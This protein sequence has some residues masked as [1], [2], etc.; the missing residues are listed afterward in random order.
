MSDATKEHRFKLITMSP[1]TLLGL[2]NWKHEKVLRLP[3]F[4][5]LPADL[6]FCAFNYDHCRDLVCIRVASMEFEPVTP[7]MMLECLGTNQFS[8]AQMTR[9]FV[10]KPD[11]GDEQLEAIIVE[12]PA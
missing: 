9:C 3:H 4:K 1:D 10:I 8:I 12:E 5:N 6:E 11:D 2:L 7:G